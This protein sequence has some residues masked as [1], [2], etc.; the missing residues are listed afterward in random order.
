MVTFLYVLVM[1]ATGAAAAVGKS[2]AQQAWHSR[3]WII[4]CLLFCLLII[5]RLLDAEELMRDNLRAAL[6]ADA[7]YDNRRDFQRPMAAAVI[8][9]AFSIGLAWIYRV[10]RRIQGRRNIAVALALICGAAMLFLIALRMISL[11][12]I[13][14]LLYGPLKLNWFADVGLSCLICVAAVLYMRIVKARP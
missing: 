9:I 8:A 12:A 14:A 10:G 13:D 3:S 6:R 7:S 5:S 1:I 4:L 11:H 2:N